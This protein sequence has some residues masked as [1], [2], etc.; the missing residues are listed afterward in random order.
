MTDERQ[1]PRFRGIDTYQDPMG[2]FSV[3]YSMD[4]EHFDI[5][6]MDGTMYVPDPADPQTS[7]SAWVAELEHPAEAEDL[8]DLGEAVDEGLRKLPECAIEG[9]DQVAL[10]N[11]LKF[12]RVFTYRDG[13]AVRKRKLWLLYVDKW[14]IALTYQGSSPEEYEYWYALAN[15]S[16]ATFTIPEALWFATDRDL[17][18][19]GRS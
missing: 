5:E 7:F 2:R 3:R 17:M 16:F 10:G 15:Y 12:E 8:V 11:L 18:G 19:Y 13:D 9:T 1:P 14:Q 6:G 4:W